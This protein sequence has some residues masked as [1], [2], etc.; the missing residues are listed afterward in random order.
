MDDGNKA[1]SFSPAA[2][3]QGQGDSSAQPEQRT[4]TPPYITREEHERSLQEVRRDLERRTQ[5]LADKVENRISARLAEIERVAKLTD[6]PAEQVTVAKQRAMM[7]ELSRTADPTPPS[8]PQPAPA[9]GGD[10]VDPINQAAA[11]MLSGYGVT[12]TQEEADRLPR[13]TPYQW[14]KALEELAKKKQQLAQTPAAARLPSMGGGGAPSDLKTAYQTDLQK[15]PR[16]PTSA[17]QRIELKAKFRQL[18][19]DPDKG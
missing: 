6:M 14:L 11:E 9:G 3:G 16:G 7:E 17:A 4:E 5:S 13:A 10:G 19:Y 12:I 1:P 18:G 8:Q 2:P 15:I